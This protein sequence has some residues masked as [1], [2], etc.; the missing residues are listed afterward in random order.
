MVD[1]YSMGVLCYETIRGQAPFC[2]NDPFEI[3]RKI[4]SEDP[5]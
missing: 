4:L 3:Y 2:G 5:T 1:C